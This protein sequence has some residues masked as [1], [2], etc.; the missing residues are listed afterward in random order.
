MQFILIS[1]PLS[2]IARH[3]SKDASKLK[4]RVGEHDVSSLN[5]PIKHEEYDVQSI[6]V[7]PRVSVALSSD[8]NITYFNIIVLLFYFFVC[9]CYIGGQFNNNSLVNDIALLRLTDPVKKKNNINIVCLPDTDTFSDQE[10][11]KSQCFI[12]G[13]GRRDECKHHQ[14]NFLS[15]SSSFPLA[16]S[17]LSSLFVHTHTNGLLINPLM[18]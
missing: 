16:H 10:L 17:L 8:N 11:L 9:T 6:F 5:E 3:Y 15:F 14:L 1:F 4:V 2:P 18:V 7:H 13:W 12:T